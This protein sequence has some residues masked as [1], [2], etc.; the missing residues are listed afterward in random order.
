MNRLTSATALILISLSTPVAGQFYEVYKSPV[1]NFTVVGPKGF[2]LTSVL[3]GRRIY[4]GVVREI[5]VMRVIVTDTPDEDEDLKIQPIGLADDVRR[6][7]PVEIQLL[8][9]V[10]LS[11]RFGMQAHLAWQEVHRLPY[12]GSEGFLALTKSVSRAVRYKDKTFAVECKYLP[13]FDESIKETRGSLEYGDNATMVMPHAL[14][15]IDSF[16]LINGSATKPNERLEFDKKIYPKNSLLG[17]WAPRP[18][19]AQVEWYRENNK[20][21]D[22]SDFYYSNMQRSVIVRGH[23]NVDFAEMGEQ[24]MTETSLAEGLLRFKFEFTKPESVDFNGSSEK[25]KRLFAVAKVEGESCKISVHSAKYPE[26]IEAAIGVRNFELFHPYYPLF[27]DE[28]D[29][30]AK[31]QNVK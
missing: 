16:R 1:D 5:D 29:P 14:A 22:W 2:K 25:V 17:W 26:R 12:R 27:L 20:S 19:A 21:F 28:G 11:G 4:S 24:K 31:F 13:G 8:T 30:R 3:P 6:H 9:P 7:S 15:F 18:S 23:G 10:N